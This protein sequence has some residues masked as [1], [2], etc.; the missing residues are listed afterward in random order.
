MK[1]TNK[2]LGVTLALFMSMG[3][4]AG[5]QGASPN[6]T[7][8]QTGANGSTQVKTSAQIQSS[9]AAYHDDEAAFNDT[10]TVANENGFTA[11]AL[12]PLEKTIQ[13]TTS[14]TVD[15]TATVGLS[16]DTKAKAAAKQKQIKENA[17]KVKNQLQASGAVTVNTDG[18]VT[19]DSAKLKSEVKKLVDNS[20]AKLKETLSKYKDKLQAKKDVAKATIEKL[21]RKNNIVRNSDVV[22]VTNAD[23][24][25]TKTITVHFEN[26]KLNLTRDVTTA[27]TT[28]DGKLVSID[29]S[30]EAKGANGYSRSAT[31]SVV[32]DAAAGTRTVTTQSTTTL[33]NG[34]VR[35]VN[36][37]RVVN[38]DGSAT[39][40]GTVTVTT[41]DGQTKTYNIG[42]GVSAGATGEE[43]TTATDTST[44]TTVT[45]DENTDGTATVVVDEPGEANDTQST[46][47]IEESVAADA[48]VTTTGDTATAASPSPST[49]ATPT[50]AP[51]T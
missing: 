32:V 51:T 24:S 9:L 4:L 18:T 14:T 11:K 50:A 3:A 38:A 12:G 43:T 35:E 39:G 36:E 49:E 44:N 46:V 23:G 19:V 2:A 29:Y 41:K 26:S 8:N 20:K 31:R 10:A 22:E 1:S 48:S 40:T 42:V 45:L 16:A 27:R 37:T 5:C 17:A 15:A 25:V 28:K 47:N 34:T 33:P 7:G 13:A 6:S 30:L 21:R